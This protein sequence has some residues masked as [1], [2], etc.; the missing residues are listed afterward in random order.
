ME[1]RLPRRDPATACVPTAHEYDHGMN[2]RNAVM[3][4]LILDICGWPAAWKSRYI[5]GDHGSDEVWTLEVNAARDGVTSNASTDF[6]EFAGPA[7]FRVGP[8]NALYVVEE[9]GGAVQKVT[10]KQAVQENC[11]PPP[12][13][14]GGTGGSGGSGGGETAGTAGASQGATGGTNSGGGT[15]GGSAG[16][17]STGKGGSGSGA[18]GTMVPNAATSSDEGGCGCRLASSSNGPAALAF[19]GGAL[20]LLLG[21]RRRRA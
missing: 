12:G 18:T 20:G 19:L 1:C 17:S 10:P 3:G 16:S 5:F 2:G 13:G 21:R 15:G 9:G 7:A 4:G 8:D 11:A 6:G 14:S